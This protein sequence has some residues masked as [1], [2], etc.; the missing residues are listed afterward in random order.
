MMSRGRS[1][2]GD[3]GLI[4]Q[5]CSGATFMSI[6][7]SLKMQHL[8]SQSC[9]LNVT[10][11]RGHTMETQPIRSPWPVAITWVHNDNKLGCLFPSLPRL[12]CKRSKNSR[13]L[14]ALTA[15]LSRSKTCWNDVHVQVISDNVPHRWIMTFVCNRCFPSRK[16]GHCFNPFGVAKGQ[17]VSSMIERVSS[18]VGHQD[19]TAEHVRH[20]FKEEKFCALHGHMKWKET[21]LFQLACCHVIITNRQFCSTETTAHQHGYQ[22]LQSC[23]TNHHL[24]SWWK[25]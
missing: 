4:A 20:F 10:L 7:D 9:E 25:L 2:Y 6:A 22:M 13:L 18:F 16:R 1:M 11:S 14:W 21:M 17:S 12:Q 23:M 24:N 8:I 19:G 3:T 5:V 15:L